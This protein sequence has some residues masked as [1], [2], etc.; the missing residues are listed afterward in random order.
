MLMDLVIYIFRQGTERI[1]CL[2]SMM[3]GKLESMKV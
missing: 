3:S 2:C 1:A